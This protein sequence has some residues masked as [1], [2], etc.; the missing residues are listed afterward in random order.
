MKELSIE[1][2]EMY[3]GGKTTGTQCF[4]AGVG[5]V[6]LFPMSRSVNQAIR[7]FGGRSI[8]DECWDS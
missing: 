2:L 5:Y 7:F 6:A 3:F 8:I 1:N 4:F